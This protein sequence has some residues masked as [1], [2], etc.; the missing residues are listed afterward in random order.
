M[1]DDVNYGLGTQPTLYLWVRAMNEGPSSE[2][3]KEIFT[4]F[5][6]QQPEFTAEVMESIVGPKSFMVMTNNTFR[7]KVKTY[8]N[9]K[10]DTDPEVLAYDQWASNALTGNKDIPLNSSQETLDSIY[11][12]YNNTIDQKFVNS[13]NIPNTY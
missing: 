12:L 5:N 10:P 8:L 1:Y 3:Y 4:Y 11:D 13:L 9:Y 2:I 6:G 7:Y